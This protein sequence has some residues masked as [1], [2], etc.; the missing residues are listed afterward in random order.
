VIN[1]TVLVE[2]PRNPE[3]GTASKRWLPFDERE[4]YRSSK[5]ENVFEIDCRTCGKYEFR[6]EPPK[7]H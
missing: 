6:D 3:H 2:C 5:D 7:R 1:T 4:T